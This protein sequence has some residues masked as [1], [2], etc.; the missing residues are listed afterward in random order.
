MHA[1]KLNIAVLPNL[2]LYNA[3]QK[4][5]CTICIYIMLWCL[6]NNCNQILWVL[7]LF[8]QVLIDV[9]ITSNNSKCP[10]DND[11]RKCF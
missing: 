2:L 11:F 8:G 1:M 4:V 3:N 7:V 5:N 9:E 10:F 6:W